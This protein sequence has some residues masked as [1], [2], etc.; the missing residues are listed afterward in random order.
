MGLCFLR[1]FLLSHNGATGTFP[2]PGIGSCSLPSHR[3]AFAMAKAPIASDI[4]EAFN[5]LTDIAAKV[6]LHL[7]TG[8]HNH[9]TDTA[10]FFLCE[11]PNPAVRI[12]SSRSQDL[13][14]SCESDPV[15]GC[16]SNLDPLISR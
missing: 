15:N 4:H 5:I 9:G 12:H 1:S 10:H 7:H 13:L 2:R 6:S 8:T 11:V 16:Q 3:Q 14:R